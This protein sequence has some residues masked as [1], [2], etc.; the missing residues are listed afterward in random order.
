ME[1]KKGKVKGKKDGFKIAHDNKFNNVR[2]ESDIALGNSSQAYFK[3][4]VNSMGK[5][6]TPPKAT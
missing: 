6:T 1:R 5:R 2:F 3:V 4:E